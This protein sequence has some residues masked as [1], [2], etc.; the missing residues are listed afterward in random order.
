MSIRAMVWALD[1][2]VGDPQAKLVLIALADHADDE[3]FQCWPSVGYIA[4]RCELGRS[5]V[6]RIIISLR[7]KGLIKH[8]K[9]RWPTGSGRSP[10]FT[11]LVPTPVPLRDTPSLQRDNPVPLPG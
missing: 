3:T 8:E 6:Y 11:L 5:T 4:K 2:P 10:L 7:D 1:T 9:R